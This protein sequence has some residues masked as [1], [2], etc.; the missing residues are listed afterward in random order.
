MVKLQEKGSV[1][2]TGIFYYLL[3]ILDLVQNIHSSHLTLSVALFSTIH[4]GG[5][6]LGDSRHQV[7]FLLGSLKGD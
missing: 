6:Y 7:I 4:E 3:P 2:K 5:E 1:L